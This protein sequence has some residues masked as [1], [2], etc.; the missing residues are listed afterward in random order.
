M[1]KEHGDKK[2][3]KFAVLAADAAL[4]ALCDNKLLIRLIRVHR[5]PYF[6]NSEGLPGGLLGPAETAEAA[7]MR[8]LSEKG[9][10]SREKLYIEQLYTFSRVN[11]DPRGRVVAVAY[12]CLVPW[13]KLSTSEEGDTDEVWWQEV[14]NLPK[15]AYDHNEIVAVALGRLRSRITYTTLMAKLMPSEFTLTELEQ[16]YESIL[17][18]GIDKR[19][20][21]KKIMK[22]KLVVSL[23]RKRVGQKHRPAM[24]YQFRSSSVLNI[25]VL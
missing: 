9:R 20:F 8:H 13:E 23:K 21:R 16:A 25:Q 17:G 12:L 19:N 11:R 3:L 14:N 24:L 6:K 4:F 15:L 18:E 1:V 10:I 2:H 5:P 7:A 22:L